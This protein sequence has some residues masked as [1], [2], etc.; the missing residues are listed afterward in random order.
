[1]PVNAF[2]PNQVAE[3][4]TPDGVLYGS[5]SFTVRSLAQVKSFFSL[6]QARD[7]TIFSCAEVV[8]ISSLLVRS[9]T[10]ITPS[11]APLANLCNEFGSFAIEYTLFDSLV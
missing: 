3:G 9:Q 10:L 8:Q 5:H 4:A 6:V 11:P 2:A 7:L 1:M